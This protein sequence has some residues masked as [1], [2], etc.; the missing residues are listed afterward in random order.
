MATFP[1]G[2]PENVFRPLLAVTS[3]QFDRDV[4]RSAY[5]DRASIRMGSAPERLN[6]QHELFGK[7]W[8]LP[9]VLTDSIVG[10]SQ[11]AVR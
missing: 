8:R 10:Q 6:E 11:D 7:H 9:L 2:N 4:P 3:R 1:T 5:H